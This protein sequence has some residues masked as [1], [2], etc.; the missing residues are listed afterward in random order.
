MLHQIV[1]TTAI[2]PIEYATTV[3]FAYLL[4][5]ESRG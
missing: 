2:S 5:Y 3:L 1:R 4:I